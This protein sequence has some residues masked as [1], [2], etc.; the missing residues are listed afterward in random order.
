MLKVKPGQKRSPEA[1][2]PA[3]APRR[4]LSQEVPHEHAG[5][6]RPHPGLGGGGVRGIRA[7]SVEMP[8]VRRH[9]VR[10]HGSLH[11]L[12]P[13]LGSAADGLGPFHR[14]PRR[15]PTFN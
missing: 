8:W 3:P 4:P 1:L 2:R 14:A 7:P 9:P 12:W 11:E 5:E 15:N 6:P 13:G 10:A